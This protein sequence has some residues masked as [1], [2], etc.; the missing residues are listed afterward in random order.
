MDAV[1][2]LLSF[3]SDTLSPFCPVQFFPSASGLGTQVLDIQGQHYRVLKQVQ[4]TLIKQ[5]LQLGNRA[6]AAHHNE[7]IVRCR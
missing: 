2:D 6:T 7:S 1:W 3:I 5:Q 4:I